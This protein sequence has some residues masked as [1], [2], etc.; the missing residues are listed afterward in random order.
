M[1]SSNVVSFLGSAIFKL[2]INAFVIIKACSYLDLPEI[3]IYD[4][5][6]IRISSHAFTHVFEEN[7]PEYVIVKSGGSS[8][9]SLPSISR[10]ASSEYATY[11]EDDSEIFLEIF[12][13]SNS[14]DDIDIEPGNIITFGEQ[15]ENN[16]TEAGPPERKRR[17][18][19]QLNI[20]YEDVLPVSKVDRFS[21]KSK[22]QQILIIICFKDAERSFH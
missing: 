22:Y 16:I 12:K 8:R 21:F 15:H 10:K 20:S 18:K 17:K 1:I 6:E 13:E 2:F 5:K 19:V 7:A 11:R 14:N 9:S 4:P 3:T